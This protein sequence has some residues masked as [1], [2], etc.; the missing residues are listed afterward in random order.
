MTE[1][2]RLQ[3]YQVNVKRVRRLL[4]QMGLDPKPKLSQANPETQSISLS[5]EAFAH[6]TL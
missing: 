4:R 1:H 2:L 5:V 6:R 3:G